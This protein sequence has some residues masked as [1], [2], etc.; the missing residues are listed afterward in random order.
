MA[1]PPGTRVAV[2]AAMVQE[3]RPLA[4]TLRLDAAPFGEGEVRS[5][6]AGDRP[7]VATVTSMGTSAARTVT[8][9]LLD[10]YE[11]DHVV[12]LGIAGGVSPDVAIGELVVPEVVVDEATGTRVHP[13]PPDGIV[14]RGVLLT[15]DVLHN[16]PDDL[17]RLIEQ[18][19]TA[20]DME[21]AAIGAVAEARGLPWTAFRAISDRAGDPN[22][23]PAVLAM[24]NADG[25]ANLPA[26][27]RYVATHPHRIPTLAKLG[28]GMKLAV[29]S[30][31]SA[32]LELLGGG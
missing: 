13:T 12:V 10:A 8:E 29:A 21:T 11:V 2:L 22:V 5:G 19:V 3:L 27:L 4:R 31:T 17:A 28:K 30:A 24:S 9:R 6:H 1:L 7:V 15:T 32:T 23:D 26:V 25:S 18:G 16:Q 14:A 20:V